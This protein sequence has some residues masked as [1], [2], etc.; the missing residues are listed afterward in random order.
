MNEF[1]KILQN[2][3]SMAT[4]PEQLLSRQASSH[5]KMRENRVGAT[6]N[7]L[8]RHDRENEPGDRG[9]YRCRRQ[10]SKERIPLRRPDDLTRLQEGLPKGGTARVTGQL[11]PARLRYWSYFVD[12]E[13]STTRSISTADVSQL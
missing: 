3:N 13:V 7:Q 1:L 9:A 5:N 11:L 6:Q 10:Q 12:A 2:M 8:H 4:K